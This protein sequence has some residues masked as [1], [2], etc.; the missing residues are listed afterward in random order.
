MKFHQEPLPDGSEGYAIVDEQGRVWEIV[1]GDHRTY[2]HHEDDSRDG[3]LREVEA[4]ESPALLEPNLYVIWR[5][6]KAVARIEVGPEDGGPAA[7]W[8][9][10]ELYGAPLSPDEQFTIEITEDG[11]AVFDAYVPHGALAPGR[12]EAVPVFELPKATFANPRY[13][14][15]LQ[16]AVSAHAAVAQARK[17]T[18]F[19]YVVHPIRVAA[20]LDRYGYAEH[21]VIAGFLH[22]VVEDTQV[23]LSEV[24]R[25]FGRRVSALVQAASEPDREAP[26]RKRKEHTIAYLRD[27]APAAALPLIAADKLD[28][29]RS[30][31]DSLADRGEELWAIFNA[32]PHEQAWYFG[33]LAVALASRKSRRPLVR[34][35]VAELARLT[36][37]LRR[38]LPSFEDDFC[39]LDEII[40]ARFDGRLQSRKKAELEDAYEMSRARCRECGAG[41]DMLA[42]FWFTTPPHGWEHPAGREGPMSFCDRDCRQV[43][44]VLRCIS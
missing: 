5:N 38:G 12:Y 22:D 14:E 4:S 25:V 42:W 7:L 27:E 32:G 39:P 36:D 43:D 35:T 16:F 34:Q 20:L 28:N 18:E 29:A 24:Q 8:R 37:H 26:W 9:F 3:S 21:V 40:R 30:V 2:I 19:P 6:N 44:L 13:L 1:Q 11:G 31:V 17:G 15:A 33:S 10:F 23:E 41:P